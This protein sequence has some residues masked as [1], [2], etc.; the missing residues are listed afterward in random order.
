MMVVDHEV[1]VAI[2]LIT[3]DVVKDASAG[4]QYLNGSP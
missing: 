4:I 1:A 2:V 3:A